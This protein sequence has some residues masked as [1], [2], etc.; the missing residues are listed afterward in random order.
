M[1]KQHGGRTAISNSKTIRT[2]KA[3]ETSQQRLADLSFS[4]FMREHNRKQGS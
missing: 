2:N 1:L 3:T 4:R